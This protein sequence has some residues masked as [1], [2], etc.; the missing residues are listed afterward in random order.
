MR[1]A[2]LLAVVLVACSK[3]E[4]PPVDS[5]AA[6]VAPAGPTPLTAADLAGNW[7]GQTMAETGD[8]VVARWTAVRVDDSSGKLV[9]EGSKDSVAYTLMVDADSMVATSVPHTDP[10]MPKGTGQVVFRS[11]GRMREGKLVGT[12]AAMLASKPDSVVMRTR[13]EATR[14]P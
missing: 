8:S 2:I 11:V 3:A 10:M 1:K 5:A 9:T 4:A 14:A 13:W 12:S 7:N 6:A